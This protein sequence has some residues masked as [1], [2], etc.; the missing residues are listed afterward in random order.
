MTTKAALRSAFVALSRLRHPQL[1]RRP[2]VPMTGGSGVGGEVS[3]VLDGA[4]GRSVVA[5]A[6][7]SEIAAVDEFLQLAREGLDDDR[8]RSGLRPLVVLLG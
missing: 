7:T 2:E 4:S 5:T 1:D 8:D 3:R 6:A